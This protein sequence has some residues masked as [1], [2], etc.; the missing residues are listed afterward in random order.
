MTPVQTLQQGTE[1][2]SVHSVVDGQSGHSDLRPVLTA[3]SKTRLEAP[4]LRTLSEKSTISRTQCYQCRTLWKLNSVNLKVI[5]ARCAAGTSQ[6][7][8]KPKQESHRMDPPELHS[9]ILSP[10]R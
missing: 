2:S 7:C 1:C 4:F 6:H 9:K 5:H 3:V 8:K 10:K